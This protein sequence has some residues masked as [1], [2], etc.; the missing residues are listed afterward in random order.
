MADATA[1]ALSAAALA[2]SAAAEQAAHRAE[3]L[4]AIKG[5]QNDTAT[6]EQARS[7]A[8]CIRTLYGSGEPLGAGAVIM[9]KTVIAIVL[10]SMAIGAW[11]GWRDEPGVETPFMFSLIGA[12]IG[13]VI[14]GVG[15]GVMF[16][17]S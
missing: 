11:W 4:I 8:S 3:C 16:L 13:L 14:A 6:V 7:Y 15:A 9:I 10:V 1:V 5:Y 17:V 2:Q 12:V